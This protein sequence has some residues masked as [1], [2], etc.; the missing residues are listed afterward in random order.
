MS[1]ADIWQY[2]RAENFIIGTAVYHKSN[3]GNQYNVGKVHAI[4]NGKVHVKSLE[5]GDVREY[6]PDSMDLL[7]VAIYSDVTVVINEGYLSYITIFTVV[8]LQT[9]ANNWEPT[10]CSSTA[11]FCTSM[12]IYICNT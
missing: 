5:D 3:V 10:A 12:Q 4:Q 11:N 6:E 9:H 1:T 2:V 8:L 7:P